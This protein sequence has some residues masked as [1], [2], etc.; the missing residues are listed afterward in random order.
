MTW[1]GRV[2]KL[3]ETMLR[4]MIEIKQELKDLRKDM[5]EFK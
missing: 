2:E 1:H 5:K 4:E 3:M